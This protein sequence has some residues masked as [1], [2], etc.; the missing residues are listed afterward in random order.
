MASNITKIYTSAKY[1]LRD[2]WDTNFEVDFR[3]EFRDLSSSEKDMID[4]ID[5]CFDPQLE[6]S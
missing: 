4:D 6:T 1:V 3:S 2:M 5:T